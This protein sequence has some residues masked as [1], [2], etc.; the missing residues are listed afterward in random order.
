MT[1]PLNTPL[2]IKLVTTTSKGSR[3]KVPAEIVVTANRIEF[4][5]SPFA[6]KDEIKAMRGSRWHGFEDPPRKIWSIDNCTRNWFK[7]K[8]LMGENPYEWFDRDIQHW[9]YDRPLMSHQISMSDYG[10]TYH[11]Q[12]LAAEQGLG[13]SLSAIEI[14]EKS[15]KTKWWWVGP[16]S[17]LYAVEREFKKWKI[18][19]NLELDIMTYEA[20]VKRMTNW[21]DKDI[22]PMGIVFDESSRLKSPTAQRTKAAM[23]IADNIREKYGMEGY[24]ILMSGTPSPKSPLDWWGQAE[25]CWPGFLREGTFEAFKYRM[26]I[27]E[28]GENLDGQSF[29]KLTTW[30]DNELKCAVCGELEDEG[31]H[32][33][34]SK[35]I[36]GLKCSKEANDFVP[37]KN[38]VAYLSERLQGLVVVQRKQDCLDLP[39]KRYR[40]IQ[41]QPSPSTLRVAQALVKSAPTTIQGLIWLRELSDGFQYRNVVTGKETCE[42]CSGTGVCDYWVDPVDSEKAFTMIDLFDPDYVATLTKTQLTCASCRGSGEVDKYERTVKE[43]P[44]PKEQALMQL[45]DENDECGRAVVFAGFTGSIDRITRVCLKHGW[46]VVRR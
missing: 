38:E 15:G 36:E 25:V 22:I 3:V 42:V 24:A 1:L 19:P 16:K 9:N 20:L 7:L 6:L 12:I 37:T 26:G 41:C 17:G 21:T 46:D 44:C 18:S 33:H 40:T 4:I 10:L 27:Y 13:K 35:M 43:V 34:V 30:K 31:S 2:A 14:M 11:Y 5:K 32:K 39:D 8:T 29:Y 23:A 28:K 45:L